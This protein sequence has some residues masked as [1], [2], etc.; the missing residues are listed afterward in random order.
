MFPSEW[1]KQQSPKTGRRIY[2]QNDV[3]SRVPRPAGGSTS[4]G[5]NETTRGPQV[6]AGLHF[7]YIFLTHSQ[8]NVA[9]QVKKQP[10]RGLGPCRVCCS[11]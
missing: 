6:L 5:Q 9:K 1:R 11:S 4:M 8:G 3:N 10:A 7:G 2:K